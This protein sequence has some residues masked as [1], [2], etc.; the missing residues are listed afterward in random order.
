[1]FPEAAL[2]DREKVLTAVA[3][4]RLYTHLFRPEEIGEP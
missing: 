4:D 2:K 3:I 1:M